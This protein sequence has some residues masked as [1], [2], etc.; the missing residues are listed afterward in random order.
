MTLYSAVLIGAGLLLVAAIC[1]KPASQRP[2]R[3]TA[4]GEHEWVPETDGDGW[5]LRCLECC[6]RTEGWQIPKQVGQK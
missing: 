1:R 6:C 4:N 3:E 5:F 2:C